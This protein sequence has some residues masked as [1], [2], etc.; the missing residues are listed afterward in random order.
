MGSAPGS[1]TSATLLG[2]LRQD[3]TD[4]AA[5]SAFVARYGPKIYG[6]CR[7]WNLQDSDAEDVTQNVLVNLAQK[8]ST[9]N[10]DPSRSF[11]SWLKTLTQHAWSDFLAKRERVG[12][13][14]G[15]SQVGEFLESIEACD[16]LITRLNA[17]F[18]IEL[19]EEASVRVRLRVAPHTW[20]AFRLTAH[21]GLSGV[22]AAQQLGLQVATVFKAKSKVQNMLREELHKLEEGP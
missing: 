17:E 7:H 9:F 21:E 8:I 18:D 19:L 12:R 10:Y 16:D 3:P 22:E 14:Q 1:R 2:R 6:W 11:R 13:G 5:W 20:E 4:Q 15:G